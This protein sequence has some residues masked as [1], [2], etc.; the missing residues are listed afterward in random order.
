MKKIIIIGCPG[1]GKSTLARKLAEKTDLPLT[2]LDLLYW[3]S[4]KTTVEEDLFVERQKSVLRQGKWII[5]G[6]Y[7]ASLEMR[8][9]ACDTIIFLDFSVEDCLAGVRERIGKKRPDMPWIETEEDQEFL[10]FIQS[11]GQTSRPKI[12]ALIEQY[13]EKSTI[14]LKNRKAV[15]DFLND[16][17]PELF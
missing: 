2:H 9:A 12:L 3:Q 16:I 14:I 5:D 11:F 6:N 10:E 1:S 15:Q 8:V 7:G 4:D 17:K 13:P